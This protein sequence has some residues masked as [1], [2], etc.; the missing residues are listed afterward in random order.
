MYKF[1]ILFAILLV[2]R[3]GQAAGGTLELATAFREGLQNHPDI[4]NADSDLQVRLA[5]ALLITEVSNPRLETE[6]RAL[7]DDPVIEVKLMQP[8]KRSY[9]G[10]R[11]HYAMIERASAQADAGAQVAGVLNDVFT[12]Y[13]ELWTVQELQQLHSRNRGDF[14]S[15]RDDLDRAVKAGQG[16]AVEL[17]LLDAEIANAAAERTALET[18]RF[19]RSAALASRIGRKDGE[20]ITVEPPSGLP[21]PAESGSLVDFAVRRTPLRLAL[22]KREEAALA[23][24]AVERADRFGPMEAGLLAEHDSRDGGVLVG[25]GFTFDLPVWNRNEA[26]IARAQAGVGVARNDL[27]LQDPDRV[28]AVIRLRHRSA[29]SAEQGAA[30]FSREVVPLFETALS[31]ARDAIAKGQGSPNQIQPIINRLTEARMRAFELWIGSLEARS[32]LE[33]ALGG[34]LEE[35]LGAAVR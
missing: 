21:I 6:F 8:I 17:S 34:R 20:V 19:S 24:L 2:L 12:R 35:A 18:T 25:V 22:I 26:G 5:E 15:L 9:F 27:R 31:Q 1:I 32:E 23:R 13:V 4:V 11:K 28:A 3:S 29:L 7:T 10:L 16:N 33:A 14:V 30:R